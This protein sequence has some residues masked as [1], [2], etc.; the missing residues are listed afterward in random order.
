MTKR[1][2]SCF[3]LSLLVFP[4]IFISCSSSDLVFTDSHA[5]SDKVWSLKDIAEFEVQVNDTLSAN[6]IT[7]MLRTGSAYP[8]RN[9]FLFVTATNPGGSAVTDTLQYFLAN[10]KGKW[11][12]KGFGDIH[13]LNLPY[14]SNVYFPSTGIYKFRIRHGMRAED[15][16]GVYDIGLRIE[17]IRIK[18]N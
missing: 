11:Y 17:K 14:K 12:G 15:L 7:I 2:I 5:I 9:I 10:E 3:F 8:F 16:E 18:R 1:K 13:A 6:N 4:L